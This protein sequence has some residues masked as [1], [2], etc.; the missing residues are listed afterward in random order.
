[1]PPRPRY[2]KGATERAVKGWKFKCSACDLEWSDK[3][4][5]KVM[6]LHM[7]ME[8]AEE[9]VHLDTVWRGDGPAP[10]HNPFDA[11]LNRAQ[12]RQKARKDRKR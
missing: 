10:P 1:M 12:K 6:E 2:P 4:Q 3:T 8:H 7:S 5:L 11:P 9:K